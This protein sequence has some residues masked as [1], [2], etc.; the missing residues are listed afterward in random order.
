MVRVDD[1]EARNSATRRSEENLMRSSLLFVAALF[2]VSLAHAAEASPASAPA[3]NPVVTPAPEPVHAA[4]AAAA[5]AVAP[6]AAPELHVASVA[7]SHNSKRENAGVAIGL[8]AAGA[9][10]VTLAASAVLMATPLGLYGEVLGLFGTPVV[11][12]VVTFLVA[13]GDMSVGR[14]LVVTGITLGAHYTGIV[15]GGLAGAVVGA[16]VAQSTLP[17]D[18]FG[19][20]P[21]PGFY[22]LF[23]GGFFG[24]LVGG[25]V[26]SGLGGGLAGA[27][28]VEE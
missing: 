22:G 24:G 16:V 18:G 26:G 14:A 21:P 28:L 3:L 8:S 15:V 2:S 10:A 9:D 1:A 19:F 6:V 5:P 23:I 27:M 11:T 13:L 4:P 20:A 25:V 12:G 7:A 17:S